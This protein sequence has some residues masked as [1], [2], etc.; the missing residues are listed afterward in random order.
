VLLEEGPAG[1]EHAA[2]LA[3]A[4]VNP[5]S[6]ATASAEYRREMV[7]IFYARAVRQA[8]ERAVASRAAVS[9]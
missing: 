8:L 5:T 9:G 6:D 1:I 2:A 3:A 4:A 7:P